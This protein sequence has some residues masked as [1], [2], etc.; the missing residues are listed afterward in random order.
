MDESSTVLIVD[1]DPFIRD[2]LTQ[3][4]EALGYAHGRSRLMDTI[5]THQ[6]GPD[7]TPTATG[8]PTATQ[9]DLFERVRAFAFDS[10][11]VLR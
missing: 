10:R 5:G 6:L 4:L 9:N 11:P 7:G 8:Q 3:K 1:E 2:V